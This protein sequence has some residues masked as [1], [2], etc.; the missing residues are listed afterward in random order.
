MTGISYWQFIWPL[1]FVLC[2]IGLIGI[3]LR[4]YGFYGPS[5]LPQH[6][7]R[8]HVTEVTHLD[9]KRKLLL[10]R[11]DKTEYLVLLSPAGDQ[12]LPLTISGIKGHDA[13]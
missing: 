3:L 5:G 7:K 12:L 8:L 6:Q 9:Y 1:L 11:C 4:K 2:L 13:T 10:V